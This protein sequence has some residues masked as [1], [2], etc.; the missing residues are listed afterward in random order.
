M[1]FIC[2]HNLSYHHIIIYIITWDFCIDKGII[3]FLDYKH[4]F[5]IHYREIPNLFVSLRRIKD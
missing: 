3:Y 1:L 5:T 4:I 2:Y